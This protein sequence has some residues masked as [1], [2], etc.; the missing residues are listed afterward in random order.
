MDVILNLQ[1]KANALG[2]ADHMITLKPQPSSRPSML[3][4]LRP[5][6][7]IRAAENT[8]WPPAHFS[9]LDIAHLCQHDVHTALYGI[10]PQSPGSAPA[11]PTDQ[12]GPLPPLRRFLA[13]ENLTQNKP[14]SAW[15]LYP[16]PVAFLAN[17]TRVDWRSIRT[18]S[19]ASSAFSPLQFYEPG[20]VMA[21]SGG[22]FALPVTWEQNCFRSGMV[23]IIEK[24]GKTDNGRAWKYQV[25]V[26]QPQA[27][28]YPR[29]APS[30]PAQNQKRN[31]FVD[32]LFKDIASTL[33]QVSGCW[34]GGTLKP[35]DGSGVDN[36]AAIAA[37]GV[38]PDSVE[39]SSNLI[40]ELTEDPDSLTTDAQTLSTRGFRNVGVRQIDW[41]A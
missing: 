1:Q 16:A 36:A 18:A 6:S 35:D 24:D 22:H 5:N 12:D 28:R 39:L 20:D 29:A 34:I 41:E 8:L 38:Q 32:K 19:N 11:Y 7:G 37:R 21:L 31:Q 15:A 3:R 2:R 9:S 17:Q 13:Y 23:V 14:G 4:G 40:S 27:P 10:T 30:G 26:F 25:V 33:R